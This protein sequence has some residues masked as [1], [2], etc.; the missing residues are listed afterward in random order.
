MMNLSGML[1]IKEMNWIV[2]YPITISRWKR[3]SYKSS[4]VTAVAVKSKREIKIQMVKISSME[5]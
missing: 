1:T 5:N 2:L 3:D 4:K